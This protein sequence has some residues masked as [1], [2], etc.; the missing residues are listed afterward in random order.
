MKTIKSLRPLKN[1]HHLTIASNPLCE[2]PHYFLYIIYQIPSL[3]QLDDKELDESIRN[4]AKDRF[5]KE[6]LDEL[7]LK[8]NKMNQEN[9]ELKEKLEL[10]NSTLEQLTQDYQKS[11]FNVENLKKENEVMQ[12]DLKTKTKLL[13]SKTSELIHLSEILY[14]IQQK[15]AFFNIDSQFDVSHLKEI[16]QGYDGKGS[17]AMESS[18]IGK[19]YFEKLKMVQDEAE[20]ASVNH[21][22]ME[23]LYNH[24]VIHD[25]SKSLSNGKNVILNEKSII[26]NDLKKL[27]DDINAHNDSLLQDNVNPFEIQCKIESLQQEKANKELSLQ[28]LEKKIKELEHKLLWVESKRNLLSPLDQSIDLNKFNYE[29]DKDFIIKSLKFDLEEKDVDITYM[30]TQIE[31]SS[32]NTQHVDSDLSYNALSELDY[33][34]IKMVKSM[35]QHF[36]KSET[37]PTSMDEACH[38]GT[39]NIINTIEE[40]TNRPTEDDI[41][42]LH[43]L[44]VTNF[45]SIEEEDDENKTKLGT[46]LRNQAI[47]LYHQLSRKVNQI[48]ELKSQ[49]FL[50]NVI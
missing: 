19:S 46:K 38:T 4:E 42:I 40:L 6:E 29:N 34:Y 32:R 27:E 48:K 49:G 15:L 5:Y 41:S 20:T 26:Q 23:L 14:Q 43:H 33:K 3:S 9:K 50:E 25:K 13:D 1:L 30:N 28:E 17:N 31:K 22:D 16:L 12:V 18:Y 47:F 37:D 35:I 24:K 10:A 21:H 45:Y 39:C 8:F 7:E 11:Q 2:I 44:K 36:D